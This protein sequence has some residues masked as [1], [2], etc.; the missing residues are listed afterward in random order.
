MRS[1]FQKSLFEPA[2]NFFTTHALNFN[3][4]ISV[5]VISRRPIRIIWS[6]LRD[7]VVR[8][9]RRVRRGRRG[10]RG[11]RAAAAAAVPAPRAHAAYT[12]HAAPRRPHVRAGAAAAA[13]VSGFA[14]EP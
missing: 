9:F 3:R 11:G 6:L 4:T 1:H 2:T 14:E 13:H 10:R 7:A 12:A 5:R 8:R